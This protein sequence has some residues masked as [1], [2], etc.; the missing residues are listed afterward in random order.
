MD[1]REKGTPMLA[2]MLTGVLT[3]DLRALR[4]GIE[5]YPEERLLWVTPPGITNSAGN[6][7]MHLAGNL[8][9]FIGAQ[10]G[11][12]GYVRDRDAEFGRRDVPRAQLLTQLDAALAAVTGTL[13]KLSDAD[14]ARPF[15]MPIAGVTITTADF[16]IH[17]ATHLTYHLGQID[18]HRR[19]VTGD[20]TA[21]PAVLPTELSTARASG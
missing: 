19:F 5:A 7:T 15:P 1:A 11:G 9:S 6:L 18:Y 2:A 21:V 20:P 17:I 16:L 8:Q 14:L 4:R 13:P 3:R 12:T 10:L